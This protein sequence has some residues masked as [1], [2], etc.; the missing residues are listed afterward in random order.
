MFLTREEERVL[1]GEEG[2]AKAKA[3]RVVV[4]VGE[5]LGA[6]KLIPIKHA[7]ISGVS[8]ENIGEPGVEF[9]EG[10]AQLGARFS[11]PTSVNPVSYDTEEPSSI[12]GLQLS[13]EYVKW[14]ERALKALGKMGAELELTCTP[15]Y[16]GIPQRYGLGAGD[17]VAWGESSAVAYANSVL[18]IRSNREGG[19]LALAAAIAGKT[20][21]YGMHIEEERRPRVEYIVEGELEE[22]EAG[23]LGEMIAL[24]HKD[25]RPPL[26]RASFSSNASL[27]EFLAAIST[28]GDLAMA[29]IA[30]VTPEEPGGEVR[31]RVTVERV[32]IEEALR[33]RGPPGEVDIVYLGC[34]HASLRELKEFLASIEGR[35]TKSKLVIS[36]SRSAYL[37]ALRE[38]VLSKALQLGA[39][40]VRDSCLVVSPF[41]KFNRSATLVTNSF[42]AYSYLSRRGMKVYMARTRELA[43]YL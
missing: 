2:E 19:P 20:Y 29:H 33:R 3:L 34:P 13:P 11:V 9:I 38:G 16:V 1:A 10:F 12:P 36:M 42:K 41:Y 18:G 27:K 31:E 40:V 22:A 15:Y 8:F 6:E 28:A 4:K 17:H 35:R 25:S 24:S 14:Q 39:A 37:E 26:V 5:A 32:Q 23:I 21:Y 30:G 7:H 43:E